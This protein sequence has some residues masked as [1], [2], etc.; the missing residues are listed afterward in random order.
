VDGEESFQHH[1]TFF[2]EDDAIDLKQDKLSEDQLRTP[3]IDNRRLDRIQ[4]EHLL[5]VFRRMA[6][7]FP[8]VYIYPDATV[9]F[10]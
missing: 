3:I 10:L 4:A 6:T 8:F 9:P 5:S 1:N 2:S 7:F